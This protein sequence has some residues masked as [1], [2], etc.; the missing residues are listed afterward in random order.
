[1]LFFLALN[2]LTVC[3]WHGIKRVLEGNEV[4]K[5]HENQNCT[6]DL[7]RILFLLPHGKHGDSW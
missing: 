4:E 6:T 3:S 7:L 2:T 5:E 1:M